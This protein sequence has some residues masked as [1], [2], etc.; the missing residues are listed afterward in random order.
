[1]FG[2]HL[3]LALSF[4]GHVSCSVQHVASF[5]AL[6]NLCNEKSSMATH[7]H[8]ELPTLFIVNCQLPDGEP[9]MFGASDDGPGK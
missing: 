5:I 6:D 8:P 7:Q 2:M 3:S 4:V 1:M 9:S